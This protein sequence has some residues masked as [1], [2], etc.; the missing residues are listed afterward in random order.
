[1]LKIVG[2][3]EHEFVLAGRRWLPYDV[4]DAIEEEVPELTG[5]TIAITT[6]GLAAGR[7]NVL[8]QASDDGSL[9]TLEDRLTRALR[10]RFGVEVP[11]ADA[12][13]AA[14]EGLHLVEAQDQLVEVAVVA[15][16]GVGTDHPLD[17][18]PVH[19]PPGQLELVV[20]HRL[21]DAEV[22]GPDPGRLQ[23]QRR[24]AG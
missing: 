18:G 17:P 8:L 24:V 11:G 12:D 13:G 4:Q 2:R 5:A 10:A 23:H 16:G 6:E 19:L 21:V 3:A 1:R 7:L 20:A 9:A 15:P 22:L 14:A